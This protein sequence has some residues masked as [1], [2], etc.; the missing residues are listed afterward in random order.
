LREEEEC[1]WEADAASFQ[2]NQFHQKVVVSGASQRRFI[3]VQL[4]ISQAP[5]ISDQPDK[6]FSFSMLIKQ[7]KEKINLWICSTKQMKEGREVASRLIEARAVLTNSPY[8][9]KH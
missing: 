8:I 4:V 3:Y 7:V 2:F 5:L 9:R 1:E 6:Q